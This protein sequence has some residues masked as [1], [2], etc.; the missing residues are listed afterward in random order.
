MHRHLTNIKNSRKAQKL[1]DTKD[2]EQQTLTFRDLVREL[3]KNVKKYD[4]EPEAMYPYEETQELFE[5]IQ[6]RLKVVEENEKVFNGIHNKQKI[7]WRKAILSAIESFKDYKLNS[8]D[9][10]K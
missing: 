8:V 6:K 7:S 3:K 5:E 1:L 10:Y 4:E 9:E 2:A